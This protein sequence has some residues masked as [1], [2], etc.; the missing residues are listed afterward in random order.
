MS[1]KARTMVSKFGCRSGST[2]PM[3][4]E[5]CSQPVLRLNRVAQEFPVENQYWNL[6]K[7]GLATRPVPG[8]DIWSLVLVP[9]I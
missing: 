5:Y 1:A 7:S 6:Y 4:L 9:V 8:A 3:V 2:V